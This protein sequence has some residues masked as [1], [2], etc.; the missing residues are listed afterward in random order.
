MEITL[1]QFN[2]FMVSYS[3]AWV[4]PPA[5]SEQHVLVICRQLMLISEGMTSLDL[6][7]YCVQGEKPLS[8]SYSMLA[9]QG[10]QDL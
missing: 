7:C 5:L 4:P 6:S 9:N 2:Y 8:I 3:L 1:F 10:L